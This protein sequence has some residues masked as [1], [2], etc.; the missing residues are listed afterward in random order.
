MH[1]LIED[2]VLAPRKSRLQYN[3]IFIVDIIII[4]I[5]YE[6][7]YPNKYKGRTLGFNTLFYSDL[8]IERIVPLVTA[9]E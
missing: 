1:S 3:I 9:L 8:N 6:L 5:L 2:E 7:F 4:D